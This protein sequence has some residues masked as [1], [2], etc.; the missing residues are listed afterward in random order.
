M[1]VVAVPGPE[2]TLRILYDSQRFEA[3]SIERMLGHLRS[4]LESLGADRAARVSDLSMLTAGERAQVLG[5]WA[6]PGARRSA[7]VCLHRLFE[8]QVER[9]PHAIALTCD[10]QA[11]TYQDLNAR[12][13]RLAHHLRTLKLGP[14][15]VVGLCLERS[16]NLV[17][18]ILAVL[19]A[20]AAYLPLDPTYPAERLRFLVDDARV[21]V[22]LTQ[23]S[24]RDRL[25]AASA[26][27]L[28]LEDMTEPLAR[29][30]EANPDSGVIPSNLAYVIYTSGSTGRP[31]GV[32]VTHDNVVRLLAGH[33]ALVPV[34]RT[35]DVWTLFHS[36][37]LR[38]LGVGDLGRPALRRAARGRALLA[39]PLARGLLPLARARNRSRC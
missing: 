6:A 38:L 3:A 32:L 11:M 15:T 9:A 27:V 39:Q 37:C 18:A 14:E 28:C 19:K 2:L 12:A 22:L 36:V 31:K 4:L 29:S 34:R 10:G 33:A 13:N 24:V 20:G 25:P 23:E 1:T 8:T 26:T 35:Q 21:P 5:D 30:S 16:P 17:V 7:P